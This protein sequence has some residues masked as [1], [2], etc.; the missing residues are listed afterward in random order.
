FGHDD[1]MNGF[2]FSFSHNESSPIIK[3]ISQE[4]LSEPFISYLQK[5][6]HILQKR[7]RF[8]PCKRS[9][10]FLAL[11]KKPNHC[12]AGND[13]ASRKKLSFSRK[14]RL[15]KGKCTPCQGHFY[16]KG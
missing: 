11:C 2:L 15:Q 14:L 7:L 6:F 8:L 13:Q 12:R 1:F 4:N 3:C 5:N 16:K 10:F 9:R